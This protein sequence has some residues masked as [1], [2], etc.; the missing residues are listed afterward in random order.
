MVTTIAKKV[1]LKDDQE[2]P[3]SRGL[4]PSLK[5]EVF[6]GEVGKFQAFIDSFEASIDSR[7]DLRAVDKLNLLKSYLK[8]PPLTLVES[9]RATAE[10]YSAAAQTLK[11]RYGN[12]LRYELTLVR[13]FLDLKA[14]AHNL[15]EL[16]HY[17][18]QYESIIRSLRNAGCD[19]KAHEYFFVRALKC[20]LNK[21][22]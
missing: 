18:T 17:P 21:E 13:G 5:V 14:P 10:N 3:T 20:R 4:L 12:Q 11:N 6:Q 15:K 19:V 1:N 2:R 9:F 16:N 8:W 7:T 22:T